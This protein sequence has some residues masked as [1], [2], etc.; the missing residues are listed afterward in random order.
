MKSQQD[1]RANRALRLGRVYGT[2]A[3]AG[4]VVMTLAG[5]TPKEPEKYTT[6]EV[7]DGRTSFVIVD[8]PGDA[9]TLSYS[10]D[11]GIELLD[12]VVGVDTVAFK[13]MNANGELDKWED[14][15]ETFE[16]RAADLAS[17]LTIEQIA[18][19]ML[20]SSHERSPADG[21]TDAQRAYISDDKLRNVLNAGPS[22]VEDN[23]TWV[24][25]AQAFA[26]TLISEDTPY[27]PVNFSSDPRSSAT[28]DSPFLSAGEG[29]SQWPSSLGLAATFSPETVSEFAQMAS[30]EY[31]ALGISNALS[32]Q[33]DLATEPRWLRVSGTFGENSELATSLAQAYVQGFQGTFDESGENL[34][35]GSGSVTTMIKHF[36]GDGMGE[37]GRE[38]HTDTGKYAV[39]PGDNFD[40]HLEP[41]LGSL[42]SAA[43]MTSYSVAVDAD[44]EPL[45]GEAV[46]T[47]YDAERVGLLRENGYKG[48]IVTDW[49][50]TKADGEP[51]AI[52]GGRA[53]GVEDL[54][55]G[56]RH[57]EVLKTGVDMF[58]GNN[59]VAPVLEAYDYWQE[60]FEAGDLDVDADT[61]F[62][63]SGSRILTMLFQPGLYDNPFVELEASEATVGSEDKI[64]A[65]IDAQLDSVV[66]LKNDGETITSSDAD[67]W[68]DKTVYIPRSY[69]T[70]FAGPFGPAQYVEA[71]TVNLEIAEKYFGTVLTDEVVLDADGK[72][73][74]YTAPDLSDV[75][76]V[77]V[78]MK[79]PDNGT[80]FSNAGKDT[81]TGAYYPL[82]LQYR[83][84][85]ADGPNVRTTSIAG[86][87][88]SDGSRQ[89]R[90]Y[91]GA[92]SRIANEADLDAFERA[93]A[94]IEA[95]GK[96]IPVLTLLKASNPVVPT[97]FES[98]SAA[99]LVGFGVSDEALIQIALGIHEPSGRLPIGFPASMD[100]VEAQLE[101]VGED[102]ETYV[103][104][105]GNDY[106]YG[107][108]LNWSGVIG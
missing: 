5:C 24:N 8:N 107:F 98:D 30:A 27:V 90:S 36:P 74:S 9:P 4:V 7:T 19:L 73:V 102:T 106:K 3:M 39:Y 28:S 49:A 85:T 96:D 84:Y 103:D 105:E 20:F 97:E 56:E 61:R 44:G 60:A 69:S 40:E 68:S 92:T 65:G 77:L 16:D 76:L 95:S 11:S 42:D 37:S 62:R 12:E 17:Q 54:T 87:I 80:N 57:F 33:I 10:P 51:G 18:G 13:D 91:F 46:G 93:T 101:D 31:R 81:Q 26:E 64:Q 32:P 71:P 59:A 43:V 63:E 50:V 35:W 25:E 1:T 14:W 79:S 83:P 53:Y 48:V 55:E 47:A 41:F 108:G 75:D 88:L 99:I 78:G 23:V 86:D 100:A 94:A 70:G 29:I 38:S 66:L 15:R 89:N 6:R 34:G 22:V 72:V 2:A 58:G 67:A 52:T 82:S 45:F 104:G 21:L